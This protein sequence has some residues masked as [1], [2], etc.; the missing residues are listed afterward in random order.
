MHVDVTTPALLFPPV[1]LLLFAYTTRFLALTSLVRSLHA[2]YQ[3][4]GVPVW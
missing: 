2:Q 4:D 1:S 3:L